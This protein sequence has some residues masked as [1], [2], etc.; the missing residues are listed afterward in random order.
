MEGEVADISDEVTTLKEE[1]ELLERVHELEIRLAVLERCGCESDCPFPEPDY[2]SNWVSI[3]KGQGLILTHD[4][5]TTEY[6]VY[7]IGRYDTAGDETSDF[8]TGEDNFHTYR[9]GGDVY[10]DI[11]Y[12]TSRMCG[13]WYVASKNSIRIDRAAYDYFADYIRVRI[14][15]L[16]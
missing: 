13:I 2:D 3:E 14:W 11:L 4:L 5:N 1:S 8:I 12:G 15:K 6:F 7:L 16:P 9:F 10:Y